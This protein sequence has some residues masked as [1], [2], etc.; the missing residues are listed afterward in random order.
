M[1]RGRPWALALRE[2]GLH[3]IG[4]G[5]GRARTAE[6][7][8]RGRSGASAA[9]R[10]RLKRDALQV[11]RSSTRGPGAA[12]AH[13]RRVP[14][15]AER[16]PRAPQPGAPPEHARGGH[17]APGAQRHRHR[18]RVSRCSSEERP[19][20]THNRT[21][22][23]ALRNGP[24]GTA[25]PLPPSEAPARRARTRLPARSALLLF[26]CFTS[27]DSRELVGKSREHPRRL[28]R[29]L[30]ATALFLPPRP[31]G[32]LPSIPV[33]ASPPAPRSPPRGLIWS[34]AMDAP[35]AGQSAPVA[36]GLAAADA[37]CSARRPCLSRPES[38][39]GRPG[40]GLGSL[41]RTSAPGPREP[42]A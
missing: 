36:G 28:S 26:L 29:C 3:R 9:G 7:R 14:P 27:G 38:L 18:K 6:I 12:A 10:G 31:P 32:R 16:P 25:T 21:R 30:P 20:P 2:G 1:A 8:R 35:S 4:S 13:G 34:P 19:R 24:P 37:R 40:L 22:E 41:P 15:R 39:G 33:P 42:R 5:R 17:A 23:A 11:G